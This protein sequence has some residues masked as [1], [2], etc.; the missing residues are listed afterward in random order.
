MQLFKPSVPDIFKVVTS[1][2]CSFW[3]PLSILPP[4]VCKK[5]PA[6]VWDWNNVRSRKKVS[7][8][9]WR[10]FITD[11]VH[12]YN[13]VWN[14]VL[15]FW[16]CRFGGAGGKLNLKSSSNL[17]AFHLPFS[18]SKKYSYNRCFYI[19]ADYFKQSRETGL[20]GLLYFSFIHSR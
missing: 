17:S 4:S 11:I 1:T 14:C 10:H 16:I 12:I 8:T 2:N 20:F 3:A 5:Y 6:K 18:F 19:Y 13:F 7:Y 15:A 9:W